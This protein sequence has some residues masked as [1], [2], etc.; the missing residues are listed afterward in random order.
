[1]KSIRKSGTA[2]VAELVNAMTATANDALE[3]VN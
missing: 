1:M 2:L 3:P